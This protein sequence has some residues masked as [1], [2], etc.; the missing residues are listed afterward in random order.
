MQR[1]SAIC[2][3]TLKN[4]RTGKLVAISKDLVYRKQDWFVP[5]A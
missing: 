1:V 2:D 3:I 4:D 5:E